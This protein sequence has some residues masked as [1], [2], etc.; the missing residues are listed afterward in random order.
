MIQYKT[1]RQFSRESGYSES[2]IRTKT[3]RN[4]W[5]EGEVWLYAPDGHKLIIVEGY[6]KWVEGD[7]K[8]Q[9]SKESAVPRMKLASRMRA[10]DKDQ[11]LSVTSLGLTNSA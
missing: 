6:N 3:Q 2:A 1:I 8:E 5:K 11:R 7:L 4:I 10:K 9:A